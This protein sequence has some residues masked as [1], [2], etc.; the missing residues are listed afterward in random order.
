[1]TH[2]VNL[3]LIQPDNQGGKFISI[4]SKV[5]FLETLSRRCVMNC[6]IARY[7]VRSPSAI[8]SCIFLVKYRSRTSAPV[9]FSTCI[10]LFCANAILLRRSGFRAYN[11]EKWSEKHEEWDT[12]TDMFQKGRLWKR[13]DEM[14]FIWVASVSEIHVNS[15]MS[16]P[17]KVLKVTFET[18]QGIPAVGLTP[19]HMSDTLHG[20]RFPR[21][22]IVCQEE[23]SPG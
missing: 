20:Q 14:K 8:P 11:E 21:F 23:L 4:L 10:V 3:R 5:V 12:N 1:M 15:E 13:S 18:A 17:N 2:R 19:F 7:W 9:N 16:Q 22:H 6:F